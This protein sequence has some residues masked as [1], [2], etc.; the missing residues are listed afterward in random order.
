LETKTFWQEFNELRAGDILI[1]TIE[2]TNPTESLPAIIGLLS[3]AP[4]DLDL[5]VVSNCHLYGSKEFYELACLVTDIWL[6][7][8]RYG[9]D[10]CARKLSKVD[11][12]ME[13]AKL[14]LDFWLQR[15]PG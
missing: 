6:P 8:L 3:E 9:N 14:G 4:E 12:Y 7:D 5:P 11:R 1:N 2:F 13:F 15:R 10:D